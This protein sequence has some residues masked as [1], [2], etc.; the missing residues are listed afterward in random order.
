MTRQTSTAAPL[1]C[2][3]YDPFPS[4]LALRHMGKSI[5]PSKA[6]WTTTHP[7][8][9]GPLTIDLLDDRTAVTW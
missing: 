7:S 8:W 3:N 4:C 2:E 9:K 6:V 1:D 5:S